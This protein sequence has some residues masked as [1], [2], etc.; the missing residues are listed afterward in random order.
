MARCQHCRSIYLER[1][2]VKVTDLYADA[3]F[4]L[5]PDH[6]QRNQ[7]ERIGYEGS[8]E[9][10]FSDA[11][12]YWAY[13]T[14]DFVID[15]LQGAGWPRRC[16]DIGA[17]TGRLLNV[18][19]SAGYVTHGIEFSASARDMAQ[20]RG[21]VMYAQSVEELE[22][23]AEGLH[24]VTALEVIEHVEDL[25]GLL[26]GINRVMADTSVFLAF[27]PSADERWF[28][29]TPGYHWLNKSFEHLVY[30][31]EAGIRYA[32]A[33]A[34]G[35]DVFV[36]TFLTVQRRDV[37]PYSI[38]V[39]LKAPASAEG[40]TTVAELWRQLR[41]LT[42]AEF[43]FTDAGPAGLGAG[44]IAAIEDLATEHPSDLPFVAAVICSKFGSSAVPLFLME[45]DVALE[46]LTDAQVVDLLAMAMHQGGI[47]FI[48][49]ILATVP[50]QRLRPNLKEDFH[51]VVDDYDRTT[52]GAARLVEGDNMSQDPAATGD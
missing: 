42:D 43:T 39:A 29:A 22:A 48:R 17:A 23:S 30:P 34:F 47:D 35:D 38:V 33:E 8:Y 31:S 4:G 14:A 21:H 20:E 6:A 40:R 50:P 11:G 13:R 3:Y 7:S 44:W 37:I 18:F 41:Y 1:I 32:L 52:G 16:L 12:F 46:R 25:R 24:V 26:G 2:P 15:A 27:Y 49:H 51:R 19:K 5:A 28:G 9:S 45:L 36:A 10:T